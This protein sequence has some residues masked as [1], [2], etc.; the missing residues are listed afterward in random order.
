MRT[1]A[2]RSQARTE[3]PLFDQLPTFLAVTKQGGGGEE[4]GQFQHPG[5]G[6]S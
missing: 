3:R 1:H 4:Y 5:V 2:Q 6:T